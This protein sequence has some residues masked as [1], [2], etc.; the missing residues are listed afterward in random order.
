TR[1]E[2]C[3]LL[4]SL[5]AH[6][7]SRTLHSFPTRRS[8]DLLFVLGKPEI[9][10]NSRL[11]QD[12]VRRPID[13][14]VQTLHLNCNHFSRPV[15]Y[16]SE[17]CKAFHSLMNERNDILHGNVDPNKLAFG[18][19]FF[20]GKVPVFTAYESFWDKSI[21]ISVQSTRMEALDKDYQTVES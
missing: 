2:S 17:P 4:S 16:T 7:P 12:T 5:L 11:F 20:N 13:I 9:K 1:L 14:R 6:Q 21:G 10:N 3:P 19:V 18:E 8:S 15:D